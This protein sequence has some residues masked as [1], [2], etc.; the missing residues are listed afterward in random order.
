MKGA[1]HIRRLVIRIFVALLTFL[2]G[3]AT[4]SVWFVNQY[5][6]PKSFRF[7]SD[8]PCRQGLVSVESSPVVPLRITI[9]DTACHS[10]QEASVQFLVENLSTKPISNYEI[11]GVQIYDELINEGL[12]VSTE[13]MEPLQP[14]QT[15]IGFLGGG[16]LKRAGG[17]PVS[18][19]KSFQLVVWSITFADGTKW[20]RSSPN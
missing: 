5:Q 14:R 6:P 8:P 3:V 2:I 19:L 13:T 20:T 7:L 17:K 15:Q 16:V 18:E 1:P 10:P 12:G 4:S 11:R 9:S